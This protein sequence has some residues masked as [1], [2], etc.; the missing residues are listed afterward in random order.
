MVSIQKEAAGLD[1]Y[2]LLNDFNHD[3]AKVILR[4]RVSKRPAWINND[5]FSRNMAMNI[6]NGRGQESVSSRPWLH[7]GW[8]HNVSERRLHGRAAGASAPLA[9]WW[10]GPGLHISISLFT[11][12][13]GRHPGASLLRVVPEGAGAP[14][15]PGA[16]AGSLLA[17]A[18]GGPYGRD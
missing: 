14:G 5:S 13:L 3:E 9:A 11:A 2:E 8:A 7:Q 4:K 6:A 17:A 12:V 10:D 16:A 18:L 1:Q 15:L